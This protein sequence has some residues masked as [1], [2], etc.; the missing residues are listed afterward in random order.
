MRVWL[1]LFLLMSPLS[2]RAGEASRYFYQGDGY[3]Q[4]RG[5]SA[6]NL[7]GRLTAL[8]DYLQDT[9]TG[10]KGAVTI[11]SGYRS[12]EYNEAL[13]RSG[14]L[15]AKASLHREGMAVDFT[16]QGV[17]ARDLWHT[18]RQLKCCGAG[19]YAGQMVHVDTG[20]ERFWD[21]KTSRVFTDISSH[22]K[23]IY[24]TTEFDIYKPGEELQWK[25][26][27]I[28]EYPF[29]LKGT[30][31][32]LNE[33]GKAIKKIKGEKGCRPVAGRE[34]A[35]NFSLKLPAT[36]PKERRLQLQSFFCEKPSP[37]MPDFVLSNVFMV[38]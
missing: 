15:A 8:L 27:R 19:Y 14:K 36:L 25:L 24:L 23:Q 18:I 13:R 4:L 3:L 16:L 38:R 32:I 10:G 2:V 37:Q 22:N 29:G 12:P 30:L 28:T 20:P 11:H 7:S 21:Q 6:Q 17:K 33:K 31:H 35:Q 26:V 1:A 34:A 5:K 9:L